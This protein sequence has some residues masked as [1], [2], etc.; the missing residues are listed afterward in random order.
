MTNIFSYATPLPRAFGKV[1]RLHYVFGTGTLGAAAL[2]GP[3]GLLNVIT[4]DGP[5][6]VDEVRQ[7]YLY[8][9]LGAYLFFL[10]ILS[11]RSGIMISWHKARNF[12]VF[13][14]IANCVFFPIGTIVGIQTLKFLRR[15]DIRTHYSQ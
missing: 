10:G 3:F 5:P 2:L 4:I 11:I 14:S 1:A 9:T 7:G 15:P 12:S 8:M 6:S 13:V